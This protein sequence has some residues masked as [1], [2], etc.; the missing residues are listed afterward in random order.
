MN[1]SKIPNLHLI[2]LISPQYIVD[3]EG[4]RMPG[5]GVDDFVIYLNQ[6]IK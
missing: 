1:N 5:I 3:K 2:G 4:E 6:L